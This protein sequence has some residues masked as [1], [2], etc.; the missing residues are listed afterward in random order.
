M[1]APSKTL[2]K[3]K[4]EEEENGEEVEE[5]TREEQE[6][7]FLALIEHRTREVEHLRKR[8][9][10]YQ[11]EVVHRFSSHFSRNGLLFSVWGEGF[12][13]CFWCLLFFL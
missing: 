7:A 4:V 1:N 11:S 13:Q 3:P 6:E 5:T 8:V 9:A 10:Y 12:F 2:K